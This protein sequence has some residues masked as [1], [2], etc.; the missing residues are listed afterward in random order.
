MLIL[1]GSVGL[2]GAADLAARAALR[3]GAGLVFLGVPDKTWA[4][5]ASK[6]D[7]AIVFPL[8]CDKEGRLTTTALPEIRS[9]L[10]RADAV[11]LGPG[12]GRSEELTE[13]TEQ[14]VGSCSVPLVLDADGLYAASRRQD[15]FWKKAACPM[16]LTPHDGEFARLSD[17][18][19]RLPR[20]DAA[21]ELAER[22]NAV[23]LLKG[24]RTR[25]AAPDGR[26][27]VNRTGNPGMATGGSGDALAG[28]IV[29]LLGQGLTPF[30]A[31]ACGAWL[32]GAAG[33][34]AAAQLKSEYA[35]LPSDLIRTLPQ[36]LP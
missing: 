31:A 4:V 35:L 32:H 12:L 26:R 22:T 34:L 6:T 29:S 17:A 23:V 27:I 33:D 28:I 30:D 7:E 3:A 9:R 25:I 5:L 1:A 24:H 36:L 15:T 13:L 18:L 11:L 20:S 19:T 8:P 21:L 10:Q 2:T 16:I 14:I